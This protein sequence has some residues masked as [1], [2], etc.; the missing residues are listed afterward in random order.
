MMRYLASVENMMVG[1][2]LSEIKKMLET[3]G[4]SVENHSKAYNSLKL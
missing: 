1:D 2:D 3:T 4:I